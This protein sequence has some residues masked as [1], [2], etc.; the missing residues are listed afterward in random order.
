MPKCAFTI[1]FFKNLFTY[2]NFIG[3]FDK[4]TTVQQRL[5]HVIVARF[6]RLRHMESESAGSEGLR[7]DFNGSIVGKFQ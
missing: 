4:D 2:Q 7:V 3:N 1:H 6:I 5:L